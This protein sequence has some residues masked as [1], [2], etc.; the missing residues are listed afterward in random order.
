MPGTLV[1]ISIKW[2]NIERNNYCMCRF[3]RYLRVGLVSTPSNSREFTDCT[4]ALTYSYRLYQLLLIKVQSQRQLLQC[5]SS[6]AIENSFCDR[7]P[8]SILAS[9]VVD[10]S[11]EKFRRLRSQLEWL[12]KSLDQFAYHFSPLVLTSRI[13]AYNMVPNAPWLPPRNVWDSYRLR[14]LSYAIGTTEFLSN[15][16]VNARKALNFRSEPDHDPTAFNGKVTR[17][18]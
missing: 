12:L 10:Q 18:N 15:A 9:M 5:D 3:T 14:L 1:W 11:S 8:R 16:C 7:V 4:F 13:S 2:Q 6:L 17:S